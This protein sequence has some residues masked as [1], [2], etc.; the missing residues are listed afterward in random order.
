MSN[1]L[2]LSDITERAIIKLLNYTGI[3]KN[4]SESTVLYLTATSNFTNSSIK[5][6]LV[7]IILGF[8]I[9]EAGGVNLYSFSVKDHEGRMIDLQAQ[10]NGYV[11]LIVNV[12]RQCVFVD[13]HYESM[14]PIQAKY[15][16]YNFTVLAFPCNQFGYQ[17]PGSDE[18]IQKF[19]KEHFDPNFPVLGKVN[20]LQEQDQDPLWAYIIDESNEIPKWNYWKYLFNRKGQ[21]VGHWNHETRIREIEPFI[22]SEV[23]H[24]YKEL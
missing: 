5:M 6:I 13:D 4:I 7:S 22:H 8:V 10:Y 1:I 15:A 2:S 11:I 3:S 19:V 20:I 16:K 9:L 17:E 23:Y 21:L 18:E 14:V 24:K 12:A